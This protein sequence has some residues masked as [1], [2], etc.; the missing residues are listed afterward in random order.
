MIYSYKNTVHLQQLK[1]MQLSK[2]ACE[3]GCHLS[4]GGMQK[5]SHLSIE[6]I[7]KGYLLCQKWYKK[8][9]GVGPRSA[10]G[11]AS[12]CKPFQEQHR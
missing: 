5:G 9:K 2:L 3:R 8:G 11:A 6:G 4:V 7:R 10:Y 12:P 1:G